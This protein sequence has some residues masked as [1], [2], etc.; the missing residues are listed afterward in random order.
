MS[1]I[2]ADR[3]KETTTS[4]GLGTITLA[5]TSGTFKAFSAIGVGNTTDAA[6]GVWKNIPRSA[7]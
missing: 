2:L 1:I 4:V 5:G 7:L 3:V 6:L